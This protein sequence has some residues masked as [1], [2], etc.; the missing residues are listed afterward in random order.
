[1]WKGMTL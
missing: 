1:M